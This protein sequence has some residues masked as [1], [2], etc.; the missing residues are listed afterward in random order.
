MSE[1][2]CIFAAFRN[3]ITLMMKKAI[4]LLSTLLIIGTVHAQRY[5]DAHITGHVINATTG[6]HIPYTTIVVKG[7]SISAVTDATGHYVMR[8]LPV[9]QYTLKAYI[10]GYKAQIKDVVFEKNKT[11]EV[12]FE[13]EED[14]VLL[15]NVVVSANKSETYRREAPTI[16]N[17][18][19]P[20]QFEN[21][22]SVSL[23]D[24]LNFQPGLRL[25]NNCQNCGFT[26]VRINGLEGTYSQILVDSRAVNSA[27]AGVY[28]LEQIP[29]NMIEQVEVVRGGGSALF[30]A[31]AIAGTIN[32]IT[33]EP[34]RNFAELRNST[35]II[36]CGKGKTGM[37]VNTSLN[38]SV[39]SNNNKAGVTLFASARQRS[40]FDYDGD[41]FTEIAKI[42]SKNVGFKAFYRTGNIG[43][44]TLEYHNINE[45]R[46][47]G[48]KLD[49]PAFKTDITEQTEHLIHSVGLKYNLFLREKHNL[50]FYTSL[51][52]IDRDSYY[53]AGRDTNAYGVTTDLTTTSGIQYIFT[54]DKF[55]FMPATLTTGIEFNYNMLDDQS[56]GYDRHIRQDVK[57]FSYYLQNEWKNKKLSLLLGGR[58]DKH[59]MMLDKSTGKKQDIPLHFSPRVT[60]RYTPWEWMILRASY[61]HGFR[62]PQTFDEDL[63]IAAV[64]GEVS[65]ISLDTNLTPEFSNSVFASIDFNKRWGRGAMSFLIEGFYTNL[66]DVFVLEE[67]GQDAAGNLLLQRMNGSGAWVG[68]INIESKIVPIRRMAIQLGFTYQQSRYKESEQWSTEVAPQKRMFRTPDTYGFLTFS[69]SPVKR[70]DINMSG[71]YTGSMLV[72]HFAGYVEKDEEI[73]T[74]S[75]FDVNFKLAYGIKLKENIILQLNIG[76]KN[77]FNSYQGNCKNEK[78]CFD[79]GE[80]RDSGFI[81]GPTLPRTLVFGVNLSL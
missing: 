73:T 5:S 62:A 30:G 69:Y 21:T 13:L 80:L 77:I 2:H 34:T 23:S 4:L 51:Q 52:H 7:T 79:R 65:L 47:G 36:G 46:R 68:G 11:V 26:Q 70:L 81:Y 55:L 25:E 35:A 71:T 50:E 20:K 16:V 1:S 37:D 14:A 49:E 18:I 43:K 53:G 8:N 78:G 15:D 39:V 27:L 19:T 56:L 44:L 32:I 9:G 38:A 60:V 64:G 67:I 22:N 61:A 17:V 3:L 31:N 75:F 59:M 74:K 76:M 12:D 33:R 54:M 72:Q 45:F 10:M 41:G 66:R 63:H 28:G 29:V 24:G 42:N 48:N 57:V 58:L 6:E 40:P